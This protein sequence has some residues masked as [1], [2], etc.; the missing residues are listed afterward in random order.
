MWK[1]APACTVYTPPHRYH[2]IKYS[3]Y[4]TKAFAKTR[5][6]WGH[7]CCHFGHCTCFRYSTTQPFTY[8]NFHFRFYSSSQVLGNILQRV[9]EW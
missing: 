1:I 6:C 5:E 3:T 2:D 8:S 7:G 4:M 9:L